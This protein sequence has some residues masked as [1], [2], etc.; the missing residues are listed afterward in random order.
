LFNS[1]DVG[2]APICLIVVATSWVVAGAR[3]LWVRALLAVL[4]PII[5]SFAWGF[6]PLLLGIFRPLR[7]GEDDRVPWIFMAVMAWSAAS[8]P[9]GAIA[10]FC[11][12][13]YEIRR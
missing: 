6:L 9:V 11:S 8:V 7:F 3:Q 4:I 2:F 1:L 12:H 5:V 10:V 13:R